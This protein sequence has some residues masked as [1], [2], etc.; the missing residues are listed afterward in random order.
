MTEEYVQTCVKIRKDKLNQIKHHCVD[1]G[2]PQCKFINEAID[3]KFNQ[4]EE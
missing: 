3:L 1:L 4:M 2:I